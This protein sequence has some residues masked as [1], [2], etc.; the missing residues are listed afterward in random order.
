M[1]GK[2]DNDDE[3][4]ITCLSTSIVGGGCYTFFA[5]QN[6]WQIRLHDVLAEVLAVLPWVQ[7]CTTLQDLFDARDE[8]LLQPSHSFCSPRLT[9]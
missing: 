6:V 5:Q 7:L 3:H 1:L 8:A 4:Q 2:N 9:V